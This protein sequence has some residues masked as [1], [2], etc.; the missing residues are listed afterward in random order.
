MSPSWYRKLMEQTCEFYDIPTHVRF[1][2][3]DDDA[4]DILLYG[5]S[6]T[7]IHFEFTSETGSQ[8]KYSKPWE[9]IIPR[10]EKSMQKQPQTGQ[11]TN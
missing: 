7:I 2:L 8:Y 3:L 5:S 1:E 4:K 11:E 10:L 6:S 9:G